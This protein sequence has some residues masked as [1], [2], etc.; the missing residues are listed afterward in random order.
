MFGMREFLRQLIAAMQEETALRGAKGLDMAQQALQIE[1]NQ[2]SFV[3]MR[4][5]SWIPL[6]FPY[7]ER[8]HETTRTKH[9]I[10]YDGDRQGKPLRGRLGL[11]TELTR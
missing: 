7:V 2:F 10:H 1:S 6:V 9:E 11:V 5:N 4:V 3:L 8:I